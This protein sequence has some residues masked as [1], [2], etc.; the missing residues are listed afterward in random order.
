MLGSLFMPPLQP[1]QQLKY[2]L[3]AILLTAIGLLQFHKPKPNSG[4]AHSMLDAS[5]H[6][7]LSMPCSQRL[8]PPPS[9]YQLLATATAY[10]HTASSPQT[11]ASCL[12]LW[13]SQS[14]IRCL[15]S[16]SLPSSPCTTQPSCFLKPPCPYH[17]KAASSMITLFLHVRCVWTARFYWLDKETSHTQGAWHGGCQIITDI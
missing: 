14:F 15:L 13:V 7:G 5:P 9:H 8:F 3:S 12:L 2:S 10:L 11:N 6:G 17:W 16:P 4:L 1:H